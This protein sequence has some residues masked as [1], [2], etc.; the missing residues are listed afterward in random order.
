MK[1]RNS[2]EKFNSG[3]GGKNLTSKAPRKNFL[4]GRLGE[5]LASAYLQK[6]GYKIIAMNYYGHWDEI[7]IITKEGEKLVFIEVKTRSQSSF[8]HG[9]E[10]FDRQKKKKLLR[11]IGQFFKNNS[12][13]QRRSFAKE[14]KSL[15]DETTFNWR[16]DL[17]EIE[18]LTRDQK[19]ASIRHFQDVL[20]E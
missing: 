14:P 12:I 8:G 5:K 19:K 17:I 3:D 16:L 11:V 10:A 9:I 15:Q 2:Q 6:K 13:Q 18:F 20:E 4:V 1:Q 7:D